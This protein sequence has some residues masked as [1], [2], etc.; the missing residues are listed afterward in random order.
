MAEVAPSEA[1]VAPNGESVALNELSVAGN[2]ESVA[3]V[4]EMADG[5]SQM[6][7]GAK[8]EKAEAKNLMEVFWERTSLTERDAEA[9][10]L[11]RGF[12]QETRELLGFRSSVRSNEKVLL[13]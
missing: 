9:L 10:C 7:D 1:M 12:K 2:G 8:E 3:A 5:K 13:E 11:K 6:A 4:E